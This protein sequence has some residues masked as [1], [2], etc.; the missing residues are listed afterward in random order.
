MTLTFENFGSSTNMKSSPRTWNSMM[1]ST[2]RSFL[3]VTHCNTLQ[4][5]ATHCNADMEFYDAGYNEIIPVRDILQH[6]ATHCN[7]GMQFYDEEYN[8]IIPVR[9]TLQR[10]STHC[11]MLQHTTINCKTDME[12][13]GAGYNEIIRACDALQ[14]GHVNL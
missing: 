10:A 6:A 7:T 8:E 11:N 12:F 9:E 1:K 4:H 2:L 3:Y 5:A 13:Y 14:H